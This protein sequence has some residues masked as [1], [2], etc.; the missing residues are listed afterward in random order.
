M[1]PSGCVWP[2]HLEQ[3]IYHDDKVFSV[4]AICNGFNVSERKF[5]FCLPFRH[6]NHRRVCPNSLRWEKEMVICTKAA[7]N[8]SANE[9]EHNFPGIQAT[10][11]LRETLTLEIKN[12]FVSLHFENF[13]SFE[14]HLIFQGI[15]A[16]SKTGEARTNK[17]KAHSIFANQY[18]H[19]IRRY[20]KK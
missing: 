15:W 5:N 19:A 20:R 17:P 9:N 4:I 13:K 3:P 7:H 2:I 16:K 6:S 1:V 12:Y 14:N 11:Q 18:A 8:S 10:R